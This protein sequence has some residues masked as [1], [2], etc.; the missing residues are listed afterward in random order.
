MS[1]V[2]SNVLA[3]HAERDVALWA[4][5]FQAL[6]RVRVAPIFREARAVDYLRALQSSEH[7]PFGELEPARAYRAWSIGWETGHVCEHLLCE[8]GRWLRGPG[9]TWASA[10]SGRALRAPDDPL[11]MSDEHRKG[12][13]AEARPVSEAYFSSAPRSAVAL[14][15]LCAQPWPEAWGG[16]RELVGADGEVV[17]RVA[18]AWNALDLIDLERPGLRWRTPLID[19]HVGGYVVS[20]SYDR[21]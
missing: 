17:L 10:V 5:T 19:H 15:H 8:L 7:Q 9:A 14:V 2:M 11:V 12:G 1:N 4:A 3:G 16:H 21:A 20:V 18:P 13:F 6:G